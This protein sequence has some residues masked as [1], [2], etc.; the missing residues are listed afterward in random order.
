MSRICVFAA[1]MLV[2]VVAVFAATTP[3]FAHDQLIA[4]NPESGQQLEVAPDVVSLEFS[5]ELL[6]LGDAGLGATVIVVDAGGRNWVDG[7]PEVR[8]HIVTAN[9]IAGM[10]GAG[11]EVRWQVVSSDGHPISGVI[12]FT[13]GDT[14]PLADITA[15]VGESGDIGEG[16]QEE[17]Q[18]QSAQ[19]SQQALR[20]VLLGASGAA[21]AVAVL[22]LTYFLRRRTRADGTGDDAP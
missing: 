17:A 11:Y 10:P 9:L 1:G 2:A 19:E 4:S 22:A 5:G 7:T 15:P 21:V 3:A 16:Q 20:V 8:E 18:D 12:P 13:V 6:V 14:E